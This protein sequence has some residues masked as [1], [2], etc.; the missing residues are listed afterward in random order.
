MGSIPA[1]PGAQWTALLR[2]ARLGR[3][4]RI[5]RFL[6][7][8]DSRE[9]W[10]DF[11]ANRAQSVMLVT[12]FTAILFM[13]ISAVV[14]LQVETRSEDSNILTGG[15]AFWW[16]LV[17]V[18]TVGYGDQYPV[19]SFGRL[20]AVPLMI[21]GVG[22][23]GVLS[24]FLAHRFLGDDDDVGDEGDTHLE[25]DMAHLKDEL[26]A[27]KEMLRELGEQDAKEP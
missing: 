20:M 4:A 22:I 18:T 19:T 12:V 25:A 6:Q 23:F 7:A 14:V 11:V 10:D 5:L 21:V 9:L 13:T 26:A 1:I 16:A 17:T 24:S 8:K 27:I 15:D 3:L 2:L